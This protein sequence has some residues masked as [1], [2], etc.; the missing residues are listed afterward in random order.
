MSKFKNEEVEEILK[1]LTINQR[2]EAQR[3]FLD[4]LPLYLEQVESEF[5]D[6]IEAV[7]S[8]ARSTPGSLEDR[9]GLFVKSV[10]GCTTEMQMRATAE[11][12]EK[13]DEIIAGMLNGDGKW[14]LQ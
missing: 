9:L 7:I 11:I 3:R 14:T 1:G 8:Q 6:K 5:W 4:V 13:R 2:I 12:D 10:E